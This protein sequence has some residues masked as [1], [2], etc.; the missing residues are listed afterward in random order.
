MKALIKFLFAR[1]LRDY[2]I[3]MIREAEK[4]GFTNGI[5][6]PEEKIAEFIEDIILGNEID[7]VDKIAAHQSLNILRQMVYKD[8][9]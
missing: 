8:N 6:L 9:I 1:K 4:R 3:K 5:D 7:G 2:I